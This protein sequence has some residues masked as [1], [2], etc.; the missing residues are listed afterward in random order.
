MKR[1]AS[2]QI[3]VCRKGSNPYDIPPLNVFS[4]REDMSKERAQASFNTREMTYFVDG[5]ESVTKVSGC[6][7]S[8]QFTQLLC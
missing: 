5:G 4:G 1:V 2:I 8:H 6:F 3:L 7:A